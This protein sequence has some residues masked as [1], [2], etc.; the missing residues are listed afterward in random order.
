VNWTINRLE[1]TADCRF[2]EVHQAI[3][4]SP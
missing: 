1:D 3:D 4:Q 2:M